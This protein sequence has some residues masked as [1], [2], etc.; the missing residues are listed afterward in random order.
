[1]LKAAFIAF[2]NDETGV[3]AIEYALLAAGIALVII[4]AVNTVGS[5]VN[6]TFT[7]VSNGLN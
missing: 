2:L 3:A 4:V 6:D 7:S 1:M 5:D